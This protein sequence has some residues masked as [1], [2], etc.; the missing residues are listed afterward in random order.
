M[1]R[2]TVIGTFTLIDSYN[3]YA[4]S[5]YI[6]PSAPFALSGNQLVVKLGTN[7][8]YETVVPPY[9]RCAVTGLFQL[10]VL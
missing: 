5:W 2:R 1:P 7:M 10:I 3:D 4:N 8:D 9:Y 6:S